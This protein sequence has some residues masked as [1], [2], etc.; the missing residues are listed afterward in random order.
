MRPVTSLKFTVTAKVAPLKSFP[1]PP[2]WNKL[3]KILPYFALA[4]LAATP[5]IAEETRQL[6][7]HEHG[8][9]Q[10][11]IAF[12][13]LKIA[14]ELHAPGA[15]IVGFEYSAESADDRAAVDAAV[16]TLARPL[17]LF[18][19][20]AVAGCSVVQASAELES[21]EDHDEHDDD[22]E[23]DEH[24]HD[25]HDE[26]DHDEHAS[27]AGHTEF[28]AQYLLTC[29]DPGAVTEIAFAYFEAFPNAKEVEVQIISDAGATSFKV[30]REARILDLR[31]LF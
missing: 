4:A 26:D 8:V 30:E 20:P 7:A 12:D 1:N 14:M 17:D 9:G 10:L 31:S 15:D 25:A 27:E 28:H 19:L 13:G 21:E 5:V 2:D 16:A 18:V 23:G 11:D 3:M 29:A 22:H 24:G 6:N